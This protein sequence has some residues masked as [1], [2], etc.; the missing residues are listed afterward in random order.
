MLNLKLVFSLPQ[1]ETPLGTIEGHIGKTV[2]GK[3]Y[4]AFEGVPY[5]QPPLGKLRFKEP[6]PITKWNGT[7]K[8]NNLYTCI[9]YYHYTEPGE[10]F[11]IGQEDCLYLNIYTNNLNPIQPYEVIFFIHGGAFMFN[12]G[13][14]YGPKILMNENVVLVTINYRLGP[15]GFLSTED[16]ILPGNN[17]LKDQLLALKWVKQ[18]IKYFGGNPDSITLSGMSAGGASVHLHY[19]SPLSIG[20]FKN[21]IALSGSS[22]NPWVLV[23][24]SLKKAKKLAYLLGCP[25]ETSIEIVNCLRTRPARQI[26]QS[27][28]HFLY[29]LYNPFSPFGVVVDIW[30]EKPFLPEHPY[31]LL[32]RGKIQD[33]PI[34]FTENE[35]EGLYPGSDFIKDEKYLE[36][37]NERWNELIPYV[38]HY[39]ETVDENVKDE[40]NEKIRKFYLGEDNVNRNSFSTVI[41]ILSDRLFISGIEDTVKLQASVTS[42][43]V[44]YYY[45]SYRGAHS[46]SE[47]PAKSNENFGACHGDDLIYVFSSRADSQTTEQDRNMSKVLVNLWLSFVRNNEPSVKEK[48]LKVSNVKEDHLNIL[49]INSPSDIK[50]IAVESLSSRNFWDSLPFMEYKNLFENKKDEL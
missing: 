24:N 40:V 46:L 19:L 33:L 49:V 36:E 45:F 35:S 26:V 20:L 32:K 37:I 15:L 21:G 13:A 18:N 1:V 17:G 3:S 30:A 4:Y 28:Q 7:W 27:V 10:D 11:V 2:S 41:K 6:Q 31:L 50:M 9:Q 5:A 12:S 25:N 8:A 16:S 29:W 44:Y 48:W 47:K 42:S 22:L 39:H 34:I 43:P 38:L 23:E 14:S